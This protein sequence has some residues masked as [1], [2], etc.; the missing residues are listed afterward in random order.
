MNRQVG[1][2]LLWV[3]SCA[4]LADVHYL[5]PWEGLRDY[6]KNPAFVGREPATVKQL[7]TL[8]GTTKPSSKPCA[9]GNVQ[10][11]KDWVLPLE[12]NICQPG[13][14][15]E[16]LSL[17]AKL[18]PD[19]RKNTTLQLNSLDDSGVPALIVGHY[20]IHQDPAVEAPGYP[21]L[22]LWRLRFT[23]DGYEAPHA[24]GFLNGTFHDSRPFG[25]DGK[26]RVVFVKHPSCVECEPN[27]Y[28]SALDF[29]GRKEDVTAFEFTYATAHDGFGT[30]IEYALP[31]HG[32]S[33]DASVETRSV[34]ASQQGPHLLQ[35]FKM[36]EGQGQ[37]DEW[38]AF[39]CVGYRCDY[40]MHTGE[41][42]AEF[43]KLWNKAKKL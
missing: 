13:R 29:D 11:Q 17:V 42:P 21:F 14:F 12:S 15:K 5:N 40:Q 20:D 30:T 2:A 27:V 43:L 36:E 35:S 34:P 18:A 32:H 16:L 4:A 9:V 7:K 8:I 28:L 25:T 31:G 6:D 33:V 38:W 1:G 22:S 24:G 26:R 41:P 37:P 10:V 23:G 3:A 19:L 39:T